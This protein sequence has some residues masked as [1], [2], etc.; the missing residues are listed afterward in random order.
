M[1]SCRCLAPLIERATAS[2]ALDRVVDFDGE[3]GEHR[4]D[5]VAEAAGRRRPAPTWGSTRRADL[6]GSSSRLA[7][8]V[9]SAPAVTPST[10]SL[11]VTPSAFFT[12]LTSASGDRRE[13]DD[14]LRG[15]R[16]VHRQPRR[17]ERQ[18]DLERLAAAPARAK[19]TT[20]GTEFATART[21]LPGAARSRRG[22]APNISTSPGTRLGCQ[23]SGGVAPVRAAP[24]GRG[25]TAR[26]SSRP[27]PRRRSASGAPS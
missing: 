2:H 6:S 12:A 17:R 24:A 20:P 11:T 10:T 23:S 25:R 22:R 18:R 8:Y 7:R 15:D 27:R 16:A 19:R 1:S 21:I 3:R 9:R 26:R 5:P 14:P 13:S 4:R